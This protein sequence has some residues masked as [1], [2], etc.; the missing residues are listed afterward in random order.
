[1]GYERPPRLSVIPHTPYPI[2][3]MQVLITGITGFIGGHLTEHLLAEG[4][5]TLFG[6]ARDGWPDGLR[7]L[8]GRAE[9]LSADLLDPAAVAA[10]VER[11]RPEWVFHLAGYPYPRQSVTEPDRCRRLNVDGSR[12]LFD[13][14]VAGGRKPRLLLASTGLV[15][16]DPDQAAETITES[17]PLRPATPYAESKVAAEELAVEVR[18]TAG[19][20][21]V[22]ARLFTSIGRRQEARYAVPEW[23]K[24]IADIERTRTPAAVPHG[25]LS[26]YRDLSDVRDVVKAFG[27]LLAEPKTAGEVYNVASGTSYLMSDVLRQLEDLA[28]G[29]VIRHTPPTPKPLVRVGIGKLTAATGWRPTHG[30]TESLTEVLNYWRGELNPPVETHGSSQ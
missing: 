12:N 7:H 5:H 9:L 23:A 20:D 2:P 11:A 30:L 22:R 6:L 16:G 18:R 29:P 19:L 26:G 3:D 28:D 14:V 21:V 1:M 17:S 15:Y 24:R 13:A 8:D 10:A 27:E 25:D 4:G